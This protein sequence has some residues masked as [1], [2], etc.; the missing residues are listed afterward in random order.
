MRNMDGLAAITWEAGYDF[1]R[2]TCEVYG[3]G[4]T[5][6]R[7]EVYS[8][9]EGTMREAETDEVVANSLMLYQAVWVLILVFSPG[10]GPWEW[11]AP[12]RTGP[13]P[14]VYDGDR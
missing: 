10:E 5:T 4:P 1:P 2:A 12:V 13:L 11:E 14:L 7:V 3:P 6:E 8:D 9:S